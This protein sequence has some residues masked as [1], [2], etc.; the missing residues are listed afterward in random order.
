[1]KDFVWIVETMFRGQWEALF[2]FETRREA[3][4]YARRHMD[5]TRVRKYQR[6]GK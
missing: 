3:R 4:N 2:S 6:V 1:M 5:P